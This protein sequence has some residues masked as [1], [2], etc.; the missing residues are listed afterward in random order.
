[1]AFFSS[2]ETGKYEM[3]KC[4]QS[5]KWLNAVPL[6][7]G[8]F[9]LQK[10]VLTAPIPHVASGN[11][12]FRFLFGRCGTLQKV[13]SAKLKGDINQDTIKSAGIS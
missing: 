1:M 5:T 7:R 10:P 8:G 2:F 11:M 6:E 3:V 13:S 4:C 9:G 12:F